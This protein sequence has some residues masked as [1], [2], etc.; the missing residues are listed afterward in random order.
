MPGVLTDKQDSLKCSFAEMKKNQLPHE[1]VKDPYS[2]DIYTHFTQEYIVFINA[3][4]YL[5]VK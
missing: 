2:I 1:V 4:K 3:N 5:E